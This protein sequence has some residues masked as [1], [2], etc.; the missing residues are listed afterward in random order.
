MSVSASTQLLVTVPNRAGQ[1][2]RVLGVVAK[3]RVNVLDCAGYAGGAEACLLLVTSN[4]S[5]VMNVLKKADYEVRKDK[6]VLVTGKDAVGQG[7]RIL[8]KVADAGINLRLVH[9]A[10]TGGR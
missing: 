9:A 5:K 4:N 10:G 7:A 1:V 8:K 2:A 6:V 3:A